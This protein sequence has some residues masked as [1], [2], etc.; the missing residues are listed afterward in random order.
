[1]E[2]ELKWFNDEGLEYLLHKNEENIEALKAVNAVIM[3]EIE[4]RKSELQQM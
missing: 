1:M 4:R 2:T 3:E